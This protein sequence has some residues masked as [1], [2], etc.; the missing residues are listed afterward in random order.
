WFTRFVILLLRL[1][2]FC[3]VKFPFCLFFIISLP[4]GMG[5]A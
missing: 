3:I 5:D 4:C 2:D 1:C